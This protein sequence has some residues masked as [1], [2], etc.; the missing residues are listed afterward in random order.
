MVLPP[1]IQSKFLFEGE[2][3]LVGACECIEV[4]R[5]EDWNRLQTEEDVDI[6]DM[7]SQLGF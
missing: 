4:W 7:A 3:V 5:P 2:V 6:D 1:D